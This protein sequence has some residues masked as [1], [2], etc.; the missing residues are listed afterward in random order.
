MKY[1]SQSVLPD[2]SRAHKPIKEV[3]IEL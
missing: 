3:F 1:K 2:I